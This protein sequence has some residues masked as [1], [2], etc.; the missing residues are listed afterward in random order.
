MNDLFDDIV[1]DKLVNVSVK[2]P[3]RVWKGVSAHLH[4]RNSF[5][6]FWAI[7]GVGCVFALVFALAPR[8][9]S[10]TPST[11]QEIYVV[12]DNNT[13][14]T[15]AFESEAFSSEIV[16]LRSDFIPRRFVDNAI[17]VNSQVEEDGNVGLKENPK[18]TSEPVTEVE[19]WEDPFAVM[20]S[21]DNKSLKLKREKAALKVGGIIGA[22]DS[23]SGGVSTHPMWSS[24]HVYD[25]VN[26]ESSVSSFSV[27]VSAGLS[28][29]FP[30]TERLSIGSGINWT[31]LNRSFKGSYNTVEGDVTHDVQYIGIPLSLYFDIVKSN[32]L[33]LYSFAGASIEKCI[34]SKYYILSE[35]SL[36]LINE[37]VK[38]LQTGFKLGI[39]G[40]FNISSLV[41]IY[42]DPF[43][44]YYVHG[45]Q[46]KSLRTEYP[47]MVSFEAGL[48]F[49]L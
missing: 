12:V 9:T 5:Q 20:V 4:G 22:N 35:S 44:S 36:P 8:H 19:E 29:C 32:R 11:I 15:L 21:E 7:A 10:S 41:S 16:S 23:H 49:N 40:S 24:G 13:S 43:V 18:K 39:G 45:N 28:I 37:K 48:R 1:R 25:G 47:L 6:P 2:P 26:E 46:P 33:R 34:S 42:F 27:P 17:M 3:K 38:E 31:L 14:H 30:L